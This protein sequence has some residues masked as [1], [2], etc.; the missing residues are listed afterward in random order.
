[1][2]EKM[3]F[4]FIFFCQKTHEKKIYDPILGSAKKNKNYLIW[5]Y[6]NFL[7][8]KKKKE[9]MKLKCQ[10]ENLPEQWRCHTPTI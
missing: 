7:Q 2:L 1:M 10:N 9:M 8:K 4:S 5:N 6:F 3:Y